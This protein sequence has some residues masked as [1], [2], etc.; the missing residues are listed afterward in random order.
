ME[1]DE[2]I[3]DTFK[4]IFYA[5]VIAIV[6]RTFLFEP[7]K[8]PSG[9]MYPTLYVGDFLFVSKY[10][11]GYSKH[12]LP[13]SLPLIKGRVWVDEPE[14][15]DVIVFKFPQDNKTDFI[16]RIIGM[17]GDKIKMENGRLYING[18]MVQRK[19]ID[20]FV[21][22]DNKG[23]AERYR[24]YIETLPNGVEHRILELSDREP[25]DNMVEVTVPQN[26]YFV[27][28]DNRNN[29]SD[30]RIFGTVNY[31]DISGRVELQ[32]PYGQTLIQSLFDKMKL[33]LERCL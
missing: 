26:S 2:S 21:N 12:S 7:F 5:I 10:T 1:K 31:D 28:G 9:S 3:W 16:K 4:T 33:L 25:V 6:I 18:E 11:Y 20:D 23:N 29:S 8:I 19:R 32:V 17:P 30:S 27:M 24:Q 14:R 13:F 22:R 15:G